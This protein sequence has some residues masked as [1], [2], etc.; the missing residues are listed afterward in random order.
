M[1]ICSLLPSITEILFEIG[2]GD[3]VVAV[4]HECDWPPR[5][6]SIPHV[7]RSRI[8]TEHSS[9]AAIDAQVRAEAGSLYDLDRPLLAELAPDVILTQSLCPVCAVDET[10]VRDWAAGLAPAPSVHAY[11]PRTIAEVLA[12]IHDI[13]R[14]TG[15][16]REAQSLVDRFRA[17]S[18]RIRAEVA[19]I[20]RPLRVVCLEWTDPPFACG[21]WTP[22]LV[23][24]AGGE[25]QLGRAGQ[26]SR[27]ATWQELRD[28]DPEVLL[29]APCGF[30]LPRTLREMSDLERREGWDALAATRR[31]RVFC[32]DGSA[33][34]NRPGPRLLDS[35]H[36]LAEAIHPDRFRSLAPSHSFQRV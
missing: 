30:T 35:L 19:A 34:F 29:I 5:A 18:Q 33:Y 11:H 8:Q 25:E 2:L 9:S 16:E 21:H 15:A 13:G 36:I 3:Q 17:S 14:V 12:S 6:Q 7:T 4:T 32:C 23:S 31:G 10:M 20:D 1:R 24:I 22:E 26:P 27:Q 28:A